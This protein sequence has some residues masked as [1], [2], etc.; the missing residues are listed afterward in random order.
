[1]VYNACKLC[2]Y[3][4]MLFH[5]TLKLILKLPLLP[6]EGSPID[7]LEF[8]VRDI[9]QI[10]GCKNR[11]IFHWKILKYYVYGIESIFGF[12][13]LYSTFAIFSHWKFFVRYISCFHYFSGLVVLFQYV[14]K[15]IFGAKFHL[16]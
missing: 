8:N 13:V 7:I 5:H 2:F 11:R 14:N 4:S 12:T 16:A 1:M 6:H 15:Y 9:V 10:Y 3:Y